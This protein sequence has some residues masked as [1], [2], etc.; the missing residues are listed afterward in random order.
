[1]DADAG[2]GLQAGLEQ[3]PGHGIGRAVPLGKGHGPDVDHLEGGLVGKLLGH[4][5][6]V[7]VHQHGCVRPQ[8]PVCFAKV[9]TRVRVVAA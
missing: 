4:A 5:A 7:L 1:M 3:A 2:A 9:D 8:R 6:Q